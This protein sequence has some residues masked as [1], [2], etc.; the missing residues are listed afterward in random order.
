[1]SVLF[2]L[3]LV[4]SIMALNDA[5]HVT[6]TDALPVSKSDV[7]S[8]SADLDGS[9][10]ADAGAYQPDA[11]DLSI[12]HPLEHKWVMYYDAPPKGKVSADDWQTHVKR[13]MEIE[14]VEDFWG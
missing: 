3:F 6:L 11:S 10:A 1:L 8:A 13:I 14:T 4:I 9:P 5:T 2:A 7:K 12:R